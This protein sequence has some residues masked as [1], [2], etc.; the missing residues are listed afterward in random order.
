MK[1]TP[2]PQ[3]LFAYASEQITGQAMQALV[4]MFA[5]SEFINANKMEELFEFDHNQSADAGVRLEKTMFGAVKAGSNIERA[6]YLLKLDTIIEKGL[7]QSG[8]AF[9]KDIEEAIK[10]TQ[11][12]A[13]NI[14]KEFG[15]NTLELNL[16][17]FLAN[18][19]NCPDLYKTLV[20]IGGAS[21]EKKLNT[22]VGG[23]GA[24]YAEPA[25]PLIQAM[26]TKQKAAEVFAMLS[27]HRAEKATIEPAVKLTGGA[28]I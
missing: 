28:K 10:T 1:T 2:T 27:Q 5:S 18:P 3:E 8:D 6:F 20:N 22:T 15:I 11:E 13:I 7:A 12:K 26:Q 19:R 16:G 4:N 24:I 21:F 14:K 9:V 25:E 23:T 17:Q